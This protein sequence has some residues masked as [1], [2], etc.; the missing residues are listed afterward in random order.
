MKI[1]QL[2]AQS[3]A[4]AAAIRDLVASPLSRYEALDIFSG[5]SGVASGGTWD[6]TTYAAWIAGID[7]YF[8]GSAAKTDRGASSDGTTHIYSYT[9]GSGGLTVLLNSGTH[10]E[11]KLG[12]F[13][14]MRW[15]DAFVN[16][17]HP[18][19]AALRETLTVIWI[20]TLSPSTYGT[21]R[22]N[23]NDVDVNR[24]FGFYWSRFTPPSPDYNKGSAAFS[25]PES[26]V[27]KA[28]FD[29]EDIAA[30]VDCHNQGPGESV[31]TLNVSPPSAWAL[32]KRGLVYGA[33]QAWANIYGGTW[34]ELDNPRE[35]NPTAYSWANYYALWNQGRPN[36]ASVLIECN[37]DAAGSTTNSIL[38][39]AAAK[40]YG[41][42]I[43]SFLLAW[44]AEGQS[45]PSPY[46]VVWNARRANN[47]D[48]VS[49][50]AG[51]TLIDTTTAT[52][53][54]FDEFS[55]TG[56]NS[57]RAYLDSLYPCPGGINIYADGYLEGGGATGARVDFTIAVNGTQQSQSI[58]SVQ[59]P[60]SA[61]QRVAFV[62]SH[63][64]TLATLDGSSI[65]R[66]TLLANRVGAGD[67]AKLK[68][69]RLWAE[70]VPNSV[71]NPS[72]NVN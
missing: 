3:P 34:A 4:T 46:G 38:S 70:F 61:T 43:T 2:T 42:F 20:P 65:P 14:A 64:I 1:S 32:G 37:A 5:F 35:G 56:G 18:T 52:A 24:N 21:A 50:T 22:K 71:T 39:A 13:A 48:A 59:A 15:F 17:S 31:N 25:E 27:I 44:L 60:A 57:S 55:P 51:G 30:F 47:N 54:T 33:A 7:A 29:A 62:L 16:S 9:A 66:I 45:A 67:N 41:G 58:C 23:S 10:G 72:P 63:R 26:S 49:I 69:F 8:G 36:F 11:E 40:N 28:I 6:A 19:M 53:L 12:Q 68:R